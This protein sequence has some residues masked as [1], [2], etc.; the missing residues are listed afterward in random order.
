MLKKYGKAA[1]KLP[2]ANS[3]VETA[4]AAVDVLSRSERRHE[5]QYSLQ[6]GRRCREYC[7]GRGVHF[8]A[9]R[10][11]KQAPRLSS[12]RWVKR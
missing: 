8:D 1:R 7:R 4:T 6:D 11:S 3:K 9:F 2:A 10:D 12:E 5:P